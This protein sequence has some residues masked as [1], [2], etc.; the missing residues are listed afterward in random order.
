MRLF[1]PDF[2][3]FSALER[4]LKMQRSIEQIPLWGCRVHDRQVVGHS[5]KH[6]DFKTVSYDL[7]VVGMVSVVFGDLK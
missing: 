5:A 2:A 3:G 4:S 7:V 6:D 1:Q